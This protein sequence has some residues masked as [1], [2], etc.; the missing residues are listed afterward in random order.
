M[1]FLIV[2]LSVAVLISIVIAL[3]LFVL[4]RKIARWFLSEYDSR[5]SNSLATE[6]YTLIL[7]DTEMSA[8]EIRRHCGALRR[9]RGFFKRKRTIRVGKSVLLKLVKE[10][11]GE[12]LERARDLYRIMGCASLAVIELRDHRWWKRADAVSE[13]GAMKV[14][15][16]LDQVLELVSDKDETV[17]IKALEAGLEI[18]GPE[19]LPV[20]IEALPEVTL[21]TIMNLAKI[22]DPHLRESDSMILSLLN[23]K[24]KDLRKFAI[25][26][27]GL[28]KSVSSVPQLVNI[29]SS[30]D[31]D[32]AAYALQ[33]LSFIEDP[34]AIPAALQALDTGTPEVKTKATLLLGQLGETDAVPS[35]SPLLSDTDA[36]VRISAAH[37]LARLGE[38]GLSILMI[39]ALE[40]GTP[41]Q[42]ASM[43]VLDELKIGVDERTADFQW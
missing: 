5:L 9:N 17:R 24:K 21:W 4:T 3:S 2:S 34:R 26:M 15:E 20:M 43:Q 40:N 23:S 33:A 14:K 28:T 1:A 11:S 36:A 6:F 37:A 30:G 10:I 13:L 38:S 22:L 27:L 42:R 31:K 8:D 41:A 29:A 35:I 12:E 16:S 18:G 19:I 25:I 32:E 7:A 39:S